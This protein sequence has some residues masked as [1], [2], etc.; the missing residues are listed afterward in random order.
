MKGVTKLDYKN[1]FKFFTLF[2]LL[3]LTTLGYRDSTET[4]VGAALGLGSYYYWSC[5]PPPNKVNFTDAN[6]YVDHR[7]GSTRIG[8]RAGFV[9]ERPADGRIEV[10]ETCTLNF[11]HE[12]H[13]SLPKGTALFV[14]PYIAGE[15]KYF[16]LGL[17][18]GIGRD[19]R[20]WWR[21]E[22][23]LLIFPTAY[24]RIGSK[25]AYLSAHIWEDGSPPYTA[26]MT[27]VGFGHKFGSKTHLWVGG[28][29]FGLVPFAELVHLPFI[30]LTQRISENC[31]M[32]V[33]GA[34]GIHRTRDFTSYLGL[35][36]RFAQ[37][38]KK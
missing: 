24:L 30:S 26:G 8:M 13:I 35:T 15:W 33:I 9:D 23:S 5:C 29:I 31:F 7:L 12:E 25:D 20:E 36:Y 21:K 28:T 11:F 6:L 14:N 16:G 17:G 37:P 2:L 22:P 4:R 1:K 38:R 19:T 34:V 10:V 3:S 27:R 32:N 18:I